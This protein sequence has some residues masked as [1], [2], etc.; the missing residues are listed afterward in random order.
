MTITI[1]Q[2]SVRVPANWL[3]PNR[4]MRLMSVADIDRW[5]RDSVRVWCHENARYGLPTIETIDWLRQR[6]AGRSVIE[7]GAG[8]GDLCHHLGICGTDSKVQR[9]NALAIEFYERTHQPRI[10]YPGWVKEI[11]AV[12]A[13][14][15]YKPEVVVASWVTHWVDPSRPPPNDAGCMFGVREDQILDLG[16]EYIMIG[17]L[18]V[19]Q[20]KPILA[21]PHEELILPFIRSR[22]ARPE[23]DRVFIWPTRKTT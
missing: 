3:L 13:V 14:R 8:A 12:D 16:C 7:I 15:H 21:L 9:N 22:S 11:D 17:N 18:A 10:R 2:Q 4:V 5:P 23:L 6:I 1:I 20:H 19:H